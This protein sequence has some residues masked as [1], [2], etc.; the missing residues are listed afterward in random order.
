VQ[1]AEHFQADHP[2]QADPAAQESEARPER[3]VNAE[4]VLVTR[5][6]PAQAGLDL[7]VGRNRERLALPEFQEQGEERAGEL[8]R[9]VVHHL[10]VYRFQAG[11][12]R[13]E[14]Q[15][16][17]LPVGERPV[18]ELP[19]GGDQLLGQVA[20]AGLARCDDRDLDA[21]GDLGEDVRDD[22]PDQVLV[23]AVVPVQGGGGHA[24]L[25][26]DGAQ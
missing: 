4:G 6:L 14:E 25:A 13:A 11:Q 1:V 15:A 24:H 3:Q 22:V 16:E 23:T 2:V 18:P 19:A 9:A 17:L 20:T 26:G 12:R 10:V 5:Q 7:A 21:V 8:L